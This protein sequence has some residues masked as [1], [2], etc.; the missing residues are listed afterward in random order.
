MNRCSRFASVVAAG[1]LLF[2]G[3]Q[4]Q[5]GQASGNLALGITITSSCALSSDASGQSLRVENHN[6]DG[7]NSFRVDRESNG[8]RS[9]APLSSNTVSEVKG[10]Q[11]APTVVTL[12]W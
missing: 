6:C 5:A 11:A 8:A 2:I 3:A 7:I 10:T 9:E 12:Y 4:A 1:A